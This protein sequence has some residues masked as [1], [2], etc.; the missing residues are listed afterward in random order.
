M[1]K[2]LLLMSLLA[3]IT[4]FQAGAYGVDTHAAI[5]QEIARFY[6]QFYPTHAFT[7][8]EIQILMDGSRAEDD[9]A[10][11]LNHF[12]DPIH[13][14]GLTYGGQ[15]TSAKVWSQNAD[16]Q[17]SYD[18]TRGFKMV[19]GYALVY[20]PQSLS[21]ADYTWKRAVQDYSEGNTARGLQGLGHI[22]HLMEDMTV[23]AHVRNDPHPPSETFGDKIGDDDPYEK[24]S[25]K[26]NPYN[27]NILIHMGD[28]KPIAGLSSL[29]SYFDVVA[30][31]TNTH[32]Y[33]D[34]TIDIKTFELPK[35]L[36]TNEVGIDGFIYRKSTDGNLIALDRTASVLKKKVDR[37]TTDS[38]KVSQ[39]TWDQVSIRV[40]QYGAGVID[41][42]LKE[43]EKLK[44]SPAFKPTEKRSL[45]GQF[46]DAVGENV[47]AL[48]Q[49]PPAPQKAV[50][51]LAT[52]PSAFP[53]S[54]SFVVDQG[55]PASTPQT[56]QPT[57][58]I[59]SPTIPAVLTASQSS[60]DSSLDTAD[61]A[62]ARRRRGGGG[63]AS[64][65]P[66]PVVAE[67]NPVVEEET[68]IDPAQGEPVAEEPP[69]EEV[70]EEE[71]A[72]EP[73]PEPE[74]EPEPVVEE[75]PVPEPEPEIIPEPEPEPLPPPDITAPSTVTDLAITDVAE[76]SFA[77]SFTAPEDDSEAGNAT[78]YD[79]RYATVPLTVETWP[80]AT[81]LLPAIT[82]SEAGEPESATLIGL[83]PHTTYYVALTSTDAAGNE[84]LIS[85]VASA[86]TLVAVP[87]H[88][89]ISELFVDMAGAD[90]GEF[91]ELYNPTESAIDI[92]NW[93]LQYL[94]GGSA[95][96]ASVAK[97]NF[98]ASAS[99]PAKGFYLIGTGGYAGAVV[100]DMTWS[101]AL[102]N[103]GATVFLVSDQTPL[104]DAASGAIIDRVAYGSGEGMLAPE[105]AAA[106][107][108]AVGSSL[109]RRRV[110]AGACST[111]QGAGE[112]QGNGCDTEQNGNDFEMRSVPKAQRSTSLPEPRSAPTAVSN[113]P[114]IVVYDAPSA[115]LRFNWSAATDGT[116]DSAT[117][118][119]QLL[120][121]SNP[122]VPIERYRGSG[123]SY[124]TGI[125]EVGRKYQGTIQAFDRDGMGS[126]ITETSITVPSYFSDF[127]FYRDPSSPPNSPAYFLK[128]KW[129]TYP[130]VPVNFSA[131]PRW[132]LALFYYKTD[133]LKTP[134]IGSL[135]NANNS[136]SQNIWGAAQNVPST[137][138][139]RYNNCYG[140]GFVTND[141]ASLIVPDTASTCSGLI[142]G[143]KSQAIDFGL[144]RSGV[145]DLQVLPPTFSG[146]NPTAGESYI[147]IAFYSYREG[148][149]QQSDMQLVAV[150]KTRYY[151]ELEP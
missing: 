70:I 137:F 21:T 53:D 107:L 146:V 29:N 72:V 149:P 48:V 103:D 54:E 74:P 67:P 79:I 150:D 130:F 109:E 92:S 82:P 105:G 65:D 135:Y 144:L 69:A 56:P 125:N 117:L 2:R 44:K 35:H 25:H 80:M 136:A 121:V 33:S 46:I 5:T 104:A 34:D 127:S 75:D 45:L 24:W 93:S 124:T 20:S 15:H 57:S 36:V 110:N 128:I 28:K 10:R 142:G 112:F 26:Y 76:D 78:S 8:P 37:V 122:E 43:V 94:S 95:G 88:P 60:V 99:I 13:N 97:K 119:Y 85:N 132:H 9:G 126:A 22:L 133:A 98:V 90:I 120:D 138:R 1:K 55:E 64:R 39:S 139:T 59:T 68:P 89:V 62:N 148:N 47:N 111:A 63:S 118:T 66:E 147:T 116:G 4:P 52:P 83:V 23:P 143:I 27:T 7:L 73:D 141:T 41:L 18:P 16:M 19:T 40:V 106:A 38:E 91:I 11:P 58:R 86:T 134:F 6:N 100:A 151:L 77:I 32:F 123:L 113:E 101:Q 50:V 108:P 51:N 131:V 114:A 145:L 61:S 140:S 129:D 96:F 84:S 49:G 115:Q 42:F 81:V 30:K 87:D 17:S 102:N 12:Y 3:L 31:Y 14:I 71:P